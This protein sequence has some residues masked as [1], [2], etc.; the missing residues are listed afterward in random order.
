MQRAVFAKTSYSDEELALKGWHFTQMLQSIELL[1]RR[2]LDVLTTELGRREKG[3]SAVQALIL[4][5]ASERPLSL[6][7]LSALG[8]YEGTNLTYNVA[9]LA[10]NGFL[11]LSRPEWDKRSSVIE[12]TVEGQEIASLVARTIGEHAASLPDIGITEEV[13]TLV[14][15]T[16]KSLH[17]RWS[18]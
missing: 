5:H 3:L 13:L 15:T 10:E 17:H 16:F 11:T 12:L 9:K 8:H 6:G 18:T 4:S 14:T 2:F 7:Q 1:H